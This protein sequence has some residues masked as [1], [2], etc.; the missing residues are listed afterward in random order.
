[1]N[2]FQCLNCFEFDHNGL[3]N[4]KVQPMFSDR[5][6]SILDQNTLLSL[7]TNLKEIKLDGQRF[8][9]SRLQKPRPQRFMN[10]DCCA[11]DAVSQFFISKHQLKNVFLSS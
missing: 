9:V 7:I 8:F 11:N 2:V 5:F 10:V 3:L 1:M 6:P 4:K